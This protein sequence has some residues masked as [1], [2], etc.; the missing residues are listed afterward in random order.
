MLI[1]LRISV[2]LYIPNVPIIEAKFNGSDWSYE[3]H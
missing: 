1:L 3:Y 2:A